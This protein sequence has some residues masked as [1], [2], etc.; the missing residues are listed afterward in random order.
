MKATYYPSST[1]DRAMKVQEMTLRAIDG[2]VPGGGDPGDLGSSNAAVE[3]AYEQ[4]R[5][6]GF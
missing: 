2:E 4:R 3:K 1:G 6:A 5:L